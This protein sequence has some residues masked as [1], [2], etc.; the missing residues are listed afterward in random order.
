LLVSLDTFR[1]LS[2]VVMSHGAIIMMGLAIVWAYLRWR[3][4][5]AFGWAMVAGALTGWAAITR[6]VDAIAFS[7]PVAIAVMI[8]LRQMSM[9]RAMVTLMLA[10]VAAAPFLMLQLIEDVG[11]TGKLFDTPYAMYARQDSPNLKMGFGAIDTSAKPQ[12][13][14]LQKQLFYEKFLLPEME[15]QTWSQVP[16][17]WMRQRIPLLINVT[18]PSVL[19]VALVPFG[20]LG[21]GSRRWVLGAMWMVYCLLYVWFPFLLRHYAVIAA[22]SILFCVVAGAAWIAAR[23]GERGRVAMMLAIALLAI[24]HLPEI[25]REVLDDGYL[26]PTMLFVAKEMPAHVKTPAIVLFRF[27]AGDEFHEEPVYNVGA[28]NPDDELIIRAHD[29]GRERDRELFDYYAKRQPE[30]EV[31]LYDRSRR[32]QADLGNVAEL[33]RRFP[34]TPAAASTSTTTA[35]ATTRSVP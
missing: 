8:E 6:P 18:L 4:Q 32:E 13:G 26:R 11:V 27:R 31:Y 33:A 7:L 22:P 3:E 16:R 25:D 14:L 28:I 15:A 19:L 1:F 17:T 21:L 10:L 34:L 9:K 35:P 20:L 5:H 2:L 24:A 30:R 23:L 12:S 29:L